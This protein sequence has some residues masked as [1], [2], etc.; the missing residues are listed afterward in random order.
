[1]T[2][3]DVERWRA[4]AS[5]AV[6]PNVYL[7][8]RWL[9]TSVREHPDAADLRLLFVEDDDLRGVLAYTVERAWADAPFRAVSTAGRFLATHAERHHPLVD[10]AASHAVVETMLTALPDAGAGLAVLRKMPGDGPLWDAL[11]A[12]ADSL[13]IPMLENIRR[14]AAYSAATRDAVA[15]E[16]RLEPDFELAHASSRSRKRTRGYVR[17]LERDAGELRLLDR[18]DEPAFTED[19]L[20]MQ[21]AGWK[22]DAERGG[23]AMRLDPVTER[24]F[25]R[26]LTQFRADGDVCALELQGEEDT[27]YSTVSLRSG[28]VWAGFLDTYHDGYAKHSAGTLG[29][30]AE[31][32]HLRRTS[33]DQPFDPNLDPF[34]AAS[35]NLY[36]DRRDRVDLI[37]APGGLRARAL[38]GVMPRARAARDT[39]RA[40]RS[41]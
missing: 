34:Y 23:L 11:T 38:L 19:F 2:E 25:S 32:N 15:P 1:M 7:D 22:G 5:R 31:L 29:R 14:A 36:P 24:W 10:P 37:L 3:A 4:L 35:T 30:I 33:A 39:L 6:E 21:V 9:L 41:R 26:I 28:G 13:R 27:V 8:P 17:A 16:D 18:S 12:S 40:R 20:A